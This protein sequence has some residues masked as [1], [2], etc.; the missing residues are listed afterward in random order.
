MTPQEIVRKALDNYNQDNLERA[1]H[2][3]GGMTDKQMSDTPFRDGAHAR[4]DG[5]QF[6]GLP[7]YVISPD[8][9]ANAVNADD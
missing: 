2:A 5:K 9:S 6:G 7:I 8:G 1:Q 3:F 4:W